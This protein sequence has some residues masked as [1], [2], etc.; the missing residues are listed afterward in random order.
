MECAPVEAEGEAF[1][2]T[3]LFQKETGIKRLRNS[4][5][6]EEGGKRFRVMVR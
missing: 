3:K 4:D 6:G 2:N 1:D 5:L